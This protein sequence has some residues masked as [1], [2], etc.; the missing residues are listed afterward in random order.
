EIPGGCTHSDWTRTD[1][2]FQYVRRAQHKIA[3]GLVGQYRVEFMD[4]SVNSDLVTVGGDAALLVRI[5]QGRD[6]RDIEACPDVILLQQ[7]EDARNAYPAA[8]LSPAQSADGFT[9]IAQLV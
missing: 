4:P 8:E 2:L 6:C 1:C 3:F 9:A 7:R 5:E